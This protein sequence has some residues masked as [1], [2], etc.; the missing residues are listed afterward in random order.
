MSES[1]HL[2]HATIARM[3]ATLDDLLTAGAIGVF[4]DERIA[5]EV[6]Q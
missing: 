3:R 1:L 4:G 5:F 6:S 2:A